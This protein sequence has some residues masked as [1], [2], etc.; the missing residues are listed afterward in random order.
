MYGGGET[1][2][3]SLLGVIAESGIGVAGGEGITQKA[4]QTN[5]L[6]DR[7]LKL[8]G[9]RPRPGVHR[10]QRQDGPARS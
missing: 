9:F 8:E 4:I 10:G 1:G 3:C 6:G 7:H 5:V 2:A